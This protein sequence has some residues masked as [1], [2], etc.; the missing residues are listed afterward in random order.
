MLKDLVSEEDKRILQQAQD[1]VERITS[2]TSE[3]D[4]IK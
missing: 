4:A 1:I 3:R 2:N